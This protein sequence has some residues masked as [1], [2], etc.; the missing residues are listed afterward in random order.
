MVSNY[1]I[2]DSTSQLKDQ[3]KNVAFL[4][5]SSQ[6][7]QLNGTSMVYHVPKYGHSFEEAAIAEHV[8]TPAPAFLG[9]S[10]LLNPLPHQNYPPWKIVACFKGHPKKN[11]NT[12]G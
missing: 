10:C 4:T 6:H 2:K 3:Q 7:F 9:A 8:G 1:Q 5:L 11:R 12:V